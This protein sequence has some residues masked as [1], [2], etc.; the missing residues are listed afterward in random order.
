[1]LSWTC[2]VSIIYGVKDVY[3]DTEMDIPFY[4][5]IVYKSVE[6]EIRVILWL[7]SKSLMFPK[8]LGIE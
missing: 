8:K 3:I 6:A 5:N 1:M 4:K 7:T 2:Q